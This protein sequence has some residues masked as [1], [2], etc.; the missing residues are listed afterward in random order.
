MWRLAAACVIVG[1]ASL[2]AQDVPQWKLVRANPD[3]AGPSLERLIFG[4]ASQLAAVSERLFLTSADGGV[5]W[6]AG[7]STNE[8]RIDA[9]AFSNSSTLWGSAWDHGVAFLG[10]SSD[11]GVSWKKALTLNPGPA[12]IV[13]IAFFDES[14]GIAVGEFALKPLILTTR[15]GGRTW[16]L[17]LLETENADYVLRRIVFRSKSEAWLVGG[18]SIWVSRNAGES[19]EEVFQSGSVGLNDIAI[20]Q[21]GIFAVGGWGAILRSQDDGETWTKIPLSEPLAGRWLYSITSL[22]AGRAWVT[23]EKGTIAS[24]SDGGQTWQLEETGRD[25]FIR[26]IKVIGDKIFAVGD[27]GIILQRP[28][29]GR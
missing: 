8:F 17:R 6:S 25:E 5:H 14:F 15:D 12:G 3:E 4:P 13:D 22:E 28:L 7:P 1:A 24:T 19:W 29:N 9:L 10:S 27:N 26:D 2:C 18:S 23:G 11:G 16:D 20:T 21:S